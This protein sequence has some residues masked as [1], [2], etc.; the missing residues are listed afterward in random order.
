MRVGVILLA[1]MSSSRLPGKVLK[2]VCGKPILEHIINRLKNI[3]MVEHLVLATTVNPNDDVLEKFCNTQDLEYFRGSEDNV[4]ERCIKAAE[5]FNL[6]VIIRMGAD[7]PFADWEVIN[8]MMAVFLKE[9]QKGNRLEYLSNN[10]KRSYP[11]G[12]DAD[13]MTLDCFRR[14]DI[15]TKGFTKELRKL[16]EINV[17]PYVHQNLDKF[18]TYSFYKDFDYSH[19]RWTLDTPEDWELTCSIYNALYAKTPDFLM[20][21]ILK[22]IEKHPRLATINSK[23]IPRSGYWTKTEKD[24]LEK[25][26]KK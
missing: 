14:I 25:R 11:L 7:T 12:L 19:L 18:K 17:V 5:A 16:N 24:K 10:L 3:S 9:H 8:E 15:E 6:D 13:I 21:E 20:D 22:Y 1:R 26:I 2:E 4:L 23:V